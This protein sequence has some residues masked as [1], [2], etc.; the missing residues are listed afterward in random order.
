[1]S[2]IHRALLAVLAILLAAGVIWA[3]QSASAG[4][5]GR[6]AQVSSAA[7]LRVPRL[8]GAPVR[9]AQDQPP[10][11]IGSVGNPSTAP[12]K[13][14]G[15]LYF[16]SKKGGASCT[17]QF[18]APRV[19]L[20]AAHCVRDNLADEWYPHDSMRFWLQYQNGT[21]SHEYNIVCTATMTAWVPK[22]KPNASDM[23]K[24]IA[25]QQTWQ[26]D[27]AMALV[28]DDSRTGFFK[29]ELDSAGKYPL[30]FKVGYPGAILGGKIVQ[31]DPG[32]AGMSFLPPNV[33]V[34]WHTNDKMS[35]GTSGGAWVAEPSTEESSSNNLLV[36]VTSFARPLWPRTSFGPYLRTRE[37]SA[38]FNYVSRGCKS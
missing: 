35:E 4:T 17:A 22:V 28:D 10:P 1:M 26:Y 8:D 36:G 29:V 5:G 3:V 15:L 14:V 18:I 27:F 20:T 12:L 21:F 25:I 7:P 11:D 24:F 2:L 34:L 13:W 31:Q 32:F 23:E 38:L 9:L 19:I 33:L 6:A 37:Y 16:K 30:A